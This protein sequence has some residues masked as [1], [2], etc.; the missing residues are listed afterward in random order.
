MRAV[1]GGCL[2][3]SVLISLPAAAQDSETSSGGLTPISIMDARPASP[4]NGTSTVSPSSVP[5]NLDRLD[6]G[7]DAFSVSLGSLYASGDFGTDSDTSIWSS[8]LAARYRTGNLRIT[9]S[10]PWMRIRSNAVIFTGID[11]TPVLVAPGT[12]DTRRTAK[13]LGDLTLGAAY[14]LTPSDT[15][16]EVE[17]SGRVKIDTATRSSGLSSGKKDYALGVQVTKPVGAVAPFVSATYRFLGD[18]STYQL[19]DGLAASAG[20]SVM[21]GSQS[22]LLAS[23]HY[24]KRATRF[25]SD[26]H[27]LFAGVTTGIPNSRFRVTG[28]GTAGLSRGA[29]GV[30]AGVALSRAF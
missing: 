19:K 24:S 8:A 21:V 12:R 15:G 2:A 7:G 4:S 6:Q 25:V 10:L 11:S 23:Y 1:I 29:A 26:A 16:L 5:Q 20:A 28:F 17:L 13:G 30:S 14:T 18:T 9:A 22:Y 27:E 3:C